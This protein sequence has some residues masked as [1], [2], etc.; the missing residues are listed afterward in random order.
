MSERVGVTGPWRRIWCGSYAEVWVDDPIETGKPARVHKCL[1]APETAPPAHLQALQYEAAMLAR[2]HREGL[3]R[4]V[5]AHTS[6]AHPWLSYTWL[7]GEPVAETSLAGTWAA[8]TIAI[9][10]LDR[11][12]YLHDEV[13]GVHGD[14]AARNVL[15]GQHRRV[16][17]IDFG[18]AWPADRPWRRQPHP[19][20]AAPEQ[21]EGRRWG[22]AADVYQAGLVIAAVA[23]GQAPAETREG[24]SR[25]LDCLPRAWRYWLQGLL[26]GDPA[27]RPTAGQALAASLRASGGGPRLPWAHWPLAGR[28][29]RREEVV[30]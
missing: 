2:L 26:H 18:N 21:R 6:G 7:P 17:L 8:R 15:V 9:G 3:P 10:L 28:Y 14:V 4:L 22:A 23:L 25:Q 12:R 13:D 1:A 16:A 24:V 20:Y 11:L 30:S 5:A 29:G 27:R 19:A